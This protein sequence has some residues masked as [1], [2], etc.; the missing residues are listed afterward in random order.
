MLNKQNR[1]YNNNSSIQNYMYNLPN[2]LMEHPLT[3]HLRGAISKLKCITWLKLPED[4][5]IKRIYRSYLIV[6]L[7]TKP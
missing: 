6:I 5:S 7:L 1:V 4:K 3:F 2:K